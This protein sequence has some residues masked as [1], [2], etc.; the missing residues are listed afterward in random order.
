MDEYAEMLLKRLAETVATFAEASSDKRYNA[1]RR[2]VIVLWHEVVDWLDDD[3]EDLEWCERCG[4]L[5]D[6]N[7][8]EGDNCGA[9]WDEMMEEDET[10]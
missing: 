8:R 7:N 2:D 6:D 1:A 4:D 3:D 5:L 10:A 9:C